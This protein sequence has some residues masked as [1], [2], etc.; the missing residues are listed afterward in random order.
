[1]S[2]EQKQVDQWASELNQIYR[3]GNPTCLRALEL[4]GLLDVYWN[5]KEDWEE[6]ELEAA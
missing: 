3:F 2:P 1:M 5:D 4:E 6:G